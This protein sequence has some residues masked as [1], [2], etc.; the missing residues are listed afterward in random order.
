M[1]SATSHI[2]AG[3]T[4]L[5]LRN[6]ADTADN[7]ILTDAGAATLRNSLTIPPSA[8]ASVPPS[9]YGSVPVKIDDQVLLFNTTSVTFTNPLPTGFRHLL[10]EWYARSDQVTTATA[11][12]LRFNNISSATYDFTDNR[13][14][15]NA[16]TSAYTAAQ[17]SMTIGVIPG[18]TA[19]A[20]YFGQ[21]FAKVMYYNGAVGNKL[22]LSESE[23][24]TS[25][26]AGG[27][28][29]DTYGG[30]WRTTG[31]AVTRIDLFPGANN[32]IAGSVFSLWG[33]P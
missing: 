18:S 15:N 6:N 22:V 2:I 29:R 21:G 31:T 19:T 26:I 23:C 14:G 16:M 28:F 11:V 25:D 27:D 33:I 3:A 4:S 13:G 9:N 30:K 20:N 17:T 10:I 32:F 1:Q 8:G 12:T 24:M 5:S 7:L